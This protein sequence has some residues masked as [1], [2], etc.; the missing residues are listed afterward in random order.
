MA[1]IDKIIT[2]VGAEKS[3]PTRNQ[4]PFHLNPP[5]FS[6]V[7]QYGSHPEL[8]PQAKKVVNPKE[9]VTPIYF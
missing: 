5:L 3:R 7:A 4:S 1:Q 8:L 9:W 2:E 6:M